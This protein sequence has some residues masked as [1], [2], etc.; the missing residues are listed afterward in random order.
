M[1]PRIKPQ[2]NH[3]FCVPAHT[4]TRN[5]QSS[6]NL[7]VIMNR[8]AVAAGARGAPSPTTKKAAKQNCWKFKDPVLVVPSLCQPDNNRIWFRTDCSLCSFLRLGD[9]ARVFE[10]RGICWTFACQLG[11]SSAGVELKKRALCSRCNRSQ[12]C[13]PTGV[14]SGQVE[15]ILAVITFATVFWFEKSAWRMRERAWKMLVFIACWCRSFFVRGEDCDDLCHGF[16][17]LQSVKK[18]VSTSDYR[19]FVAGVGTFRIDALDHITL[20][21]VRRD[22]SGKYSFIHRI[23]VDFPNLLL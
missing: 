11:L 13:W 12:W 10:R 19:K 4:H 5:N 8:S 9:E 16:T 6:K 21:R 15:T 7:A 20:L 23:S 18:C 2:K 1:D 14:M 22:N 17:M 3:L